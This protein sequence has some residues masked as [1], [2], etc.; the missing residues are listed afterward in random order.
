MEAVADEDGLITID[1]LVVSE[2]LRKLI[3]IYPRKWFLETIENCDRENMKLF[4]R[5]VFEKVCK[6]EDGWQSPLPQTVAK[7]IEA[8]GLWQS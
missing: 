2:N 7:M 1:N 3:Q 4:S 6:R 8:K 5:D